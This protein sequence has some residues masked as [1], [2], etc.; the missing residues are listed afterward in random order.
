MNRWIQLLLCAAVVLAA[1]I[2]W[3][4]LDP[5]HEA[6]MDALG[7]PA[8]VISFLTATA[9]VLPI[10]EPATPEKESAGGGWA[11]AGALVVTAPVETALINDRMTAIGDGEAARSVTAVPLA[12]GVLTEV[13]VEAGARVTA[14][15]VLAQLDSEAEEIARDRAA[16]AVEMAADTVERYERLRDARTLTEVQRKDAANELQNARLALREAEN[17]LQRRSITAPIGG[18]VG[19]VPVETGDYVTPQTP[20]T[21][22]DDRSTILVDFWATERFAAIIEVGQEVRADPIALPGERFTGR[23]TAIGSRIDRDSRTLQVRAEIDNA[24]DTLRPGMSFRVTMRFP[25]DRYA[26]INPLALQWSS[27]GAF[28]WRVE[29]GRAHRVDVRI[30]Q[31]NSDQVLVDAALS[32]GEVVVIEGVQSVRPGGEVRIAGAGAGG[33]T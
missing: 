14:G 10:G 30:I 29:E 17:T 4:R 1:G 11:S 33:E 21:T 8:P 28:V 23:V 20:I 3:V 12:S 15:Q 18:I 6:R 27:E 5:G 31:R 32:E 7:L 13:L 16:L 26:A 22:I 19:I 25:G 9:L 2:G 24:G